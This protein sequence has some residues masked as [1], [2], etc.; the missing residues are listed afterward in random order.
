[1]N[2]LLIV[3]FVVLGIILYQDLKSRSIW[4]FLP[5]LLFICNVIY[6]IKSIEFIQLG[7]NTLFILILLSCLYVYIY[8]RHQKTSLFKDFFGIG[9]ALFLFAIAPLFD[10]N[11]FIYFFT[12]ATCGSLIIHLIV[13]T[14]K[15]QKTIPYAG[16]MSLFLAIVLC[17]QHFDV[18]PQIPNY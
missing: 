9:D 4:W 11:L 2:Y 10:L 13:S 14:F 7:L 17:L 1:M 5:L 6:R 8:L 3:I 18:L 12:A 16:Y 15:A